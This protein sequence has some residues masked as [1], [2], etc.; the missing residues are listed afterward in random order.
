MNKR[1]VS[2][3]WGVVLIVVITIIIAAIVYTCVSNSQQ[4]ITKEKNLEMAVTSYDIENGQLSIKLG[5]INEDENLSANITILIDELVIEDR[6]EVFRHTWNEKE[7][8][9]TIGQD[10]WFTDIFNITKVLDNSTYEITVMCTT[11]H[12]TD[13]LTKTFYIFKE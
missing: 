11:E 5:F 6:I 1:G 7:Y 12:I 3:V 8:Q 2:A 4:N 9:I 13:P 10:I